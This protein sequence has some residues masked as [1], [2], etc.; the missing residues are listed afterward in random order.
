M[1]CSISAGSP[2][3]P[4]VYC[5]CH[6]RPGNDHRRTT[7][8]HKLPI[9]VPRFLKCNDPLHACPDSRWF[10]PSIQCSRCSSWSKRGRR[11]CPHGHGMFGEASECACP[12]VVRHHWE[13]P[14]PNSCL[15][16]E[17]NRQM[18]V[19]HYFVRTHVISR[20]R[21]WK[22]TIYTRY[23]WA[24]PLNCWIHSSQ[25]NSDRNHRWAAVHPGPCRESWQCYALLCV[26]VFE[27]RLGCQVLGRDLVKTPYSNF[28]RYQG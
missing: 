26:E 3:T 14:L 24:R 16:N 23:S 5:H 9:C 12:K 18:Q 8:C 7:W 11:L 2:P 22:P 21:N 6:R 4:L 13:Y 20:R 19:H 1:E 17:T 28:G 27:V 25:P 10:C 15:L